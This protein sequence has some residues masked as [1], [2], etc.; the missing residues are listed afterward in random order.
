[1]GMRNTKDT[2]LEA[3]K[4]KLE[5]KMQ[6][7]KAQSYGPGNGMNQSECESLAHAAAEYA[8]LRQ[9]AGRI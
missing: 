9:Q 3:A 1:M 2:T 8:R 4:N 7:V 6:H 5:A